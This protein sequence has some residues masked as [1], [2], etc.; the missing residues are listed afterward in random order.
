[1]Q[2][3]AVKIRSKEHPDVI[4]KAIPGHFVTRSEERRVGKEC[5]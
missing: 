4:L 5:L 2:S 3:K 1:M